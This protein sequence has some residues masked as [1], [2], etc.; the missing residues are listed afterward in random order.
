MTCGVKNNLERAV[1]IG[2]SE[3]VV[4]ADLAMYAL[5][6]SVHYIKTVSLEWPT[7]ITLT[8]PHTNLSF[9]HRYSAPATGN[10]LTLKKMSSLILQHSF[11]TKCATYYNL[12]IVCVS[13][14]AAM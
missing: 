8:D 1:C 5:Q 9:K 4:P 6:T 7:V 13:A 3:N 11:A 12:P 2:I 10:K 14:S